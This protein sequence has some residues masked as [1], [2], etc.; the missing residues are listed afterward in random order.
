MFFMALCWFQGCISWTS[1]VPLPLMLSSS[2]TVLSGWFLVSSLGALRSILVSRL[3]LAPS[4]TSRSE[5]FW[6]GSGDDWARAPSPKASNRRAANIH[7]CIGLFYPLWIPRRMVIK[8]D[9]VAK[10]GS[11]DAK[12][13]GRLLGE[14]RPVLAKSSGE[15]GKHLFTW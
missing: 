11:V 6:A 10:G 3:E 8:G 7:R 1:L 12:K 5:G 2:E 14:K 13:T 15:E 9:A 4:S